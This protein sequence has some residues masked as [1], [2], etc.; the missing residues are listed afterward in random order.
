L[1]RAI[2]S[3]EGYEQ[4][5]AHLQ[6]FVELAALDVPQWKERLFAS[7]ACRSAIRRGRQ[8][9]TGEQAALIRTLAQTKAPA[10][11]PHGSPILLCYSRNFLIDKF[12]W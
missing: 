3:G 1:I 4:V 9:S 6:E 10:V 5:T 2:P 12:S 8:L 7:L 11:C